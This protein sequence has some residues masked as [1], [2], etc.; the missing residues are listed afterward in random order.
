MKYVSGTWA[1]STA[2]MT[3]PNVVNQTTFLWLEDVTDNDPGYELSIASD[4]LSGA[5]IFWLDNRTLQWGED[6][7]SVAK[8]L[9]FHYLARPVEMVNG[10]E[11]PDLVPEDFHE[12]LVLS[13]GVY[14][15][16]KAD[17][18][19]PET[20]RAALDEARLDFW[21]EVSIA[22]PRAAGRS[23]RRVD[24]LADYDAPSQDRS[25]ISSDQNT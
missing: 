15:R 3:V 20:W 11:I 19:A 9:R 4:S 16:F 17:E 8:T 22:R 23:I 6:G 2:T 10:N 5:E 18:G 25:S 14:L 12:L 21:K 13:A 7:P 1:A 24:A